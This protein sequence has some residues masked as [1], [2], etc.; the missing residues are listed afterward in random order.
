MTLLGIAVAVLLPGDLVIV[1]ELS[2]IR[3]M[4]EEVHGYDR[5]N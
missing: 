5:K 3:S 2:Y 1:N 4:I